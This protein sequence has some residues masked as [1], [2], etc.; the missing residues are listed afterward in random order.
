MKM[1]DKEEKLVNLEAAYPG[2]FLTDMQY[3]KAR[4]KGACSTAY[5]RESAAERL[6]LAAKCLP[7]G[8][9][10][11]IW[12]AWRTYETQ[13]DLYDEYLNLLLQQG[14]PL[15]QAQKDVLTFV[16]FPSKDVHK[17]FV[18]GTGGAVDLTI[19]D[20]NGQELWMG[21][22]FDDFSPLASTFYFQNQEDAEQIHKNRMLL[23]G[24]M[25]AQGF[26]NLSSE[27]WHYDYGDRFWAEDTGKPVMY[28][29][30]F[31]TE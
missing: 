30:I 25:T 3:A 23:Y 21:T 28:E 18:H 17:T 11:L 29:G 5:M 20:E 1:T 6:A 2:V 27:W 22:E 8:Y 7:E 15:Q 10:F 4:R 19:V 16:S 31:S 24:A 14:M 12:D 13:K 9:R 26:T